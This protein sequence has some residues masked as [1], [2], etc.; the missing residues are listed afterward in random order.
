MFIRDIFIK[1]YE[2]FS[3]YKII[4][5]KSYNVN[6]SLTI[7]LKLLLKNLSGLWNVLRN[8][9]EIC[10]VYITCSYDKYVSLYR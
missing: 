7:Q 6:K 5:K 9:N 2:K 1:M 4:Y 3:L 10:N 8:L